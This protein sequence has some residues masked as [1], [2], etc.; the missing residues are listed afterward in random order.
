MKFF[1]RY[2]TIL[3]GALPAT[4]LCSLALIGIIFGFGA[5]LDGETAGLLVGGWGLAGI[6]GTLSLWAVGF[7]FVRTWSSCSAWSSPDPSSLPLR[8]WAC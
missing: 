5:A 8:G 4:Y 2:L 1:G 7:G 6:Y 3:F